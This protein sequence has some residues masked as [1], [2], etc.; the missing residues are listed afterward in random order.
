MALDEQLTD[1]QQAEIARQWLREN[2][3]FIVGGIVV[4][5]GGLFGWQQWQDYQNKQAERASAL[6]EELLLAVRGGRTTQADELFGD[7][8]ERF[9]ASAYV[10]QARFVLAKSSM[11]RNDFDMAGEHL[12]AI[13]DHTNSDELR[14]IATLRLARIRLQQQQLDEALAV[15]GTASPNSA[16]AARYDDVRGDIYY[17]QERFDEA[18]LAYEAALSGSAE[19]PVIDRVYVQAKLDALGGAVAGD[20]SPAE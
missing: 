4:A 9:P 5:V 2:L 8:S 11:D 18:R 13:L 19:A 3:A 7:M 16:F 15:L 12:A 6:Y 1:E 20:E 14:H 17:E 10:D